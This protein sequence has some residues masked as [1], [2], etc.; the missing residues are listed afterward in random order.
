MTAPDERAVALEFRDGVVRRIAAA[1]GETVLAAAQRAGVALVHQCESGS[2]GTCVARLAEGAAATVPGRALALL[3]GEIRDGFRLTCSVT[4][5]RDSRFVFDYPSALLE[6]ARPAVHRAI[7]TGIEWIAKS[8]ARLEV[9]IE[10]GSG[11][12]FESGQYVR[13]RVPGSDAWRS[14]SMATTARELPRMRFLIRHIAGGAMSEWLRSEGAVGAPVEVEG[15]M[16]S[17]RLAAPS[18]PKVMVAGGTG[19]A[20]ILAMLDTLRTRP[21]PKAPILLC[22]GCTSA[23]DLFYLDELELRGFWMPTLETRIALMER[24]SE[25]FGG[26]IGSV[27]SLLENADCAR[28]GVTAYVCGPPAMVEAARARLCAGGMPPAAIHAEQFRAT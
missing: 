6:A 24:P 8:V 15:P 26:K 18:G 5:E 16:G 2:C 27:V 1:P 13:I 17:F 20:P 3:P 9:E 14:Y 4:A 23:E 21:G 7:A 22:F 11:F 25:G 28:P 19:I 10:R 12:T